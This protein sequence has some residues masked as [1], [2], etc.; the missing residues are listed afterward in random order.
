VPSFL[1]PGI[2]PQGV[3]KVEPIFQCKAKDEATPS[4]PVVKE[5]EEEDKGK[6]VEVLNSK[7]ESK[8]DFEVFN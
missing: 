3:L 7:D 5:E 1:N 4:H 2:E 6:V 8:E